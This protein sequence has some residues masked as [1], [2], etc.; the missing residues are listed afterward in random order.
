MPCVSHLL[1]YNSFHKLYRQKWFVYNKQ[2][3]V[4]E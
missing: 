2:K 3:E 4:D 1:T